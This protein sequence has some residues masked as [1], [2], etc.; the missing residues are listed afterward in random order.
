M[1][2][3]IRCLLAT[4]DMVVIVIGRK[5]KMLAPLGERE[6]FIFQQ[7]MRKVDMF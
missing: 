4:N 2:A 6:F 5:E 3:T 7:P 1:L